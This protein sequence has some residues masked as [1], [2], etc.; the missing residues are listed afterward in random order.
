M[1]CSRADHPSLSRKT[2]IEERPTKEGS[3]WAVTV[4]PTE[5]QVRGMEVGIGRVG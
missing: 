1:N 5:M 4:E 3:M 2:L